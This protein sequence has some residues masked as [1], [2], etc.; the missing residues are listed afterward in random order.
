MLTGK[1]NKRFEEY[2]VSYLQSELEQKRCVPDAF[3]FWNIPLSMQFGILQD[4]ADS[5]GYDIQIVTNLSQTSYGVEIYDK[6]CVQMGEAYNTRE[7]AIKAAIKAFDDLV[8][9]VN[10]KK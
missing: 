6:K 7:E 9:G 8:N 2:L 3:Q 5:I 10:R 4:Y 1:N